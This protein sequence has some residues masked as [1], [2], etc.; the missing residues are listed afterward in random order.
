M[1]IQEIG[2]FF[3][4]NLNKNIIL[5]FFFFIFNWRF[6]VN[7][8]RYVHNKKHIFSQEMVS[9]ET[10][11]DDLWISNDILILELDMIFWRC[12]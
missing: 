5:C 7:C 11:N 4:E 8:I 3:N 12:K 10:F 2:I 6:N 1:E 9:L